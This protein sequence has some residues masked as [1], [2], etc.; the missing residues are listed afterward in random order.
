MVQDWRLVAFISRSDWDVEIIS[1][2]LRTI[3]WTDFGID[4][5]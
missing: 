1:W 2:E 5:D 4:W 3:D